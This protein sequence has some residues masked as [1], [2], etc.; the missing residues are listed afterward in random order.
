MKN[1]TSADKLWLQKEVI[2]YLRCSPSSFPSCE[3]YA[4]LKERAIKDGR[5]R[6]YKKSDVLTFL[7]RLQILA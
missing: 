1:E 5:R 2:E 4:W 7:E 6:K 3:R